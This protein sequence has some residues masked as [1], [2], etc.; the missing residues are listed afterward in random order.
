V[1]GV[2]AYNW[3]LVRRRL[4]DEVTTR[5]LRRSA[6]LELCIAL[7][8]VAVTAVLVATPTP[9]NLRSAVPR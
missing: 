5:Q 8:V 4:G 7:V 3:R 6:T 1:V 2:G 9:A